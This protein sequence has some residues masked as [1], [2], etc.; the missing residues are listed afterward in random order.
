[1]VEGLPSGN[2]PLATTLNN[3][4]PSLHSKNPEEKIK[5]IAT[6]KDSTLVSTVSNNGEVNIWNAELSLAHLG[7]SNFRDNSKSALS[8]LSRKNET[9]LVGAG[10]VVSQT[11]QAPT[12]ATGTGK[13]EDDLIAQSGVVPDAEMVDTLINMGFPAELA[14]KALILTNNGGVAGALDKIL[15]LQEEE[16]NKPQVQ[17]KPVEKKPATTVTVTKTVSKPKK[18]HSNII[19]PKWDCPACTFVNTNKNKL[20]E[21]CGCQAPS[22]AYF[23]EEELDEKEEEAPKQ[24]TEQKP[25]QEAQPVIPQK[26]FL[27]VSRVH[28]NF[29]V[30]FKNSPICP[31]AVGVVF[32]EDE[33]SPKKY[34]F[35]LRRFGYLSS[36]LKKFL[37]QDTNKGS[38]G[39]ISAAWFGQ[40]IKLAQQHLFTQTYGINFR[41]LEPLFIGNQRYADG[42]S[43]GR[44]EL[45][46]A[47]LVA[48]DEIDIKI[49]E[50]PG[51]LAGMTVRGSYVDDG[52]EYSDMH[53]LWNQGS[54]YVLQTVKILNKIT[55]PFNSK[56]RKTFDIAS[57]NKH[58]IKLSGNVLAFEATEDSLIIV[59][60]EQ[61]AIFD[62]N[63]TESAKSTSATKVADAQSAQIVDGN[64]VVLVGKDGKVHVAEINAN[65]IFQRGVGAQS[66]Q[67]AGGA[68]QSTTIPKVSDL[69]E[70]DIDSI[71][72]I[73][74]KKPIG[75]VIAR[76]NGS[77]NDLNSQSS[78]R[79][80]IPAGNKSGSNQKVL[81]V[82]FERPTSLIN[83][84]VKSFFDYNPAQGLKDH[85]EEVTIFK[86]L[87]QYGETKSLL[88]K[89]DAAEGGSQM[90]QAKA[91]GNNLPTLT[92]AEG[93]STSRFLPLTVNSFKGAPHNEKFPVAKV[94]SPNNEIFCTNYPGTEFIFEHLHEKTMLVK[95]VTVHSKTKPLGTMGH[96]IGS[97]LI[98][99][100]NTL[101]FLSDIEAYA[102]MNHK[103][104]QEWFRKRSKTG[105]EMQP[106]EPVG[107][108]EFTDSS[109]SLTIDLSHIRP[110]RYILLKPTNMRVTPQDYSAKFKTSPLEIKF[111]GAS[112]VIVDDAE[113]IVQRTATNTAH[114]ADSTSFQIEAKKVDGS[115]IKVQSFSNIEIQHLNE[116]SKTD[117]A[118][119]NW[120]Q[121]EKIPNTG[122]TTVEVSNEQIVQNQIIGLRVVV[123][124]AGSGN[125]SLSGVSIQAY[126]SSS[127]SNNAQISYSP[128]ALR[129]LLLDGNE[130]DKFN[131]TL[132]N[133]LA[134][135]DISV[136]KRRKIT[137]LISEIIGAD[138]K[139]AAQFYASFDLKS[140]ITNCVLVEKNETFAEVQNLLRHFSNQRGFGDALLNAVLEILPTISDAKLITSIGLNGFFSLMQWCHSL[141]TKK[142]FN[143]LLEELNKV[144]RRIKDIRQPDYNILRAQYNIPS[145]VFEK[146]LFSDANVIRKSGASSSSSSS[147]GSKKKAGADDDKK[148]ERNPLKYKYYTTY[149]NDVDE[150]VVDLGK[151]S[152]VDEIRL[153]FEQSSR[154]LRFRVQIWAVDDKGSR[155]VHSRLY[156]DS[157][158]IQLASYAYDA[159]NESNFKP[160]E[161]L[162][163]LGFSGF[164]FQTR[165]LVIQ[166]TYSLVPFLQPPYEKVEKKIVPEIYGEEVG[167]ANE[168][169]A[170]VPLFNPKSKS[171]KDSLKL[172]HTSTYEKYEVPG[173]GTFIKKFLYDSTGALGSEAIADD[174][175]PTDSEAFLQNHLK[176]LQSELSNK[177]KDVRNP[178]SGG[179]TKGEI[180]EVCDEIEATLVK[181]LSVTQRPG[182]AN[183]GQSLD[184]L[185]TLAVKLSQMIK[186]ID[187]NT[188]A[189]ERVWRSDEALKGEKGR[190]IA[191]EIFEYLIVYETGSISKEFISLLSDFLTSNLHESEWQLFNITVINNFLANPINVT[192]SPLNLI[193]SHIRIIEALDKISVP[194]GELLSFVVNKL[195]IP[196]GITDPSA[197]QE[198][199]SGAQSEERRKKDCSVL[200]TLASVLLLLNNGYK[201]VAQ[202]GGSA[203]DALA[204][205]GMK[206]SLSSGSN[207]KSPRSS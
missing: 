144:A 58:E 147:A 110:C 202:A 117:Y 127:S 31:V 53:M 10:I 150:Y 145:L 135:S 101:S 200:C 48:C 97:G 9:G 182:L 153:G 171:H 168:L 204:P 167:P 91:D 125:W 18:H 26:N 38:F 28:S 94:V 24:T 129:K 49:D 199:D 162:E 198:E 33:E 99:T 207:D 69:S 196:V 197:K 184:F 152:K 66:D 151:Q 17:P 27:E 67:N 160:T 46:N 112:G 64:A 100:S 126:A 172:P 44:N 187:T 68:G 13:P 63:K 103:T 77:C 146:E 143:I 107:S 86:A 193:F 4:P 174:K 22:D 178:N 188:D 62:A 106:N 7:S 2:V 56:E 65:S 137:S 80:Y 205:P 141:D 131:K 82:G 155:L 52:K 170:F 139:L 169:E 87:K 115:W 195:N 158:Y 177:L 140:F 19:K 76:A 122:S 90:D 12:T 72:G 133:E 37:L 85:E 142:V 194:K 180:Q 134:R 54:G 186:K 159:H 42:R 70:K 104:F 121:F 57:D 20:C 36:Y 40:D 108:F 39:T 111:F 161:E 35:R 114:K 84:E 157:T 154:V 47:D 15:Q 206:R 92:L 176:S 60:T 164:N 124:K 203:G 1:M 41:A 130:F 16:K 78:T 149:S 175:N 165:Y 156:N 5:N 95:S 89:S 102:D 45:I 190:K 30:P 173:K 136:E 163:C 179:A 23:D 105:R 119:D 50:A 189:K 191:L 59:T 132:V 120:S 181:L 183:A 83:I 8:A 123:D 51:K 148:K 61:I 93:D 138:G 21:I 166:L 96:P 75:G 185:Y 192:S 88:R 11:T 74:H 43:H 79:F 6:T 113:S 14:K 81:E 3:I 128:A 25:G 201:K 98:F 55:D 116:S 71:R 32:E 118:A 34:Q 29:M 73:L 109:E